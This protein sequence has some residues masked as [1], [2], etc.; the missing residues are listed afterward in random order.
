MDTDPGI[1]KLYFILS[2]KPVDMSRY[3]D[4]ETGRLLHERTA[5]EPSDHQAP[6]GLGTQLLEW[7]KNA[8]TSIAEPNSKGIQIEGYGVSANSAHPALVEVDLKHRGKT[9][10]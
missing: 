2:P 9:L 10:L 6:S 1:E 4:M 5:D 3:F 7:S 8:R